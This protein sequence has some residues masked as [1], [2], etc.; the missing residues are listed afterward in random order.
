V[1]ECVPPPNALVATE[2]D[3]PLSAPDAMV[4]IFGVVPSVKFTVP[5]GVPPELVTFAAS[6]TLL[7]NVCV[8]GL[9]LPVVV[10][11]VPT[12]TLI[13]VANTYG[14]VSE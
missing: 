3:P 11:D 14:D 1:I 10:V 7:P 2:A 8:D 13:V 12:V 4:T 9:A 5:V 6:V